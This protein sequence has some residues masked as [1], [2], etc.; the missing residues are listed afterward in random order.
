MAENVNPLPTVSE[1]DL[2]FCVTV[3]NNL[4]ARCGISHTISSISQCSPSLFV[5][6]FE[7]LFHFRL[8]NIHREKKQTSVEKL[9]NMKELISTMEWTVGFSLQHINAQGILNGEPKHLCLLIQIFKEL[10]NIVEHRKEKE[11][12]L[13]R[14]RTPVPSDLEQDEEEAPQTEADEVSE[15]CDTVLREQGLTEHVKDVVTLNPDY[16]MSSSSS[17]NLRTPVQLLSLSSQQ[18][19]GKDGQAW[20]QGYSTNSDD[21]PRE[22]TLHADPVAHLLH[23]RPL[24]AAAMHQLPQPL[25]ATDLRAPHLSPHAFLPMPKSHADEQFRVLLQEQQEAGEADRPMATAAPRDKPSPSLVTAD[26]QAQAGTSP[27][28]PH[29]PRASPALQPPAVYSPQSVHFTLQQLHGVSPLLS[30][31]LEG[32]FALDPLYLTPDPVYPAPLRPVAKAPATP[33]PAAATPT[34]PL[35][36]PQPTPSTATTTAMAGKAPK[37]ALKPGAQMQQRPSATK[38]QQ[39]QQPKQLPE[40]KHQAL[41]RRIIGDEKRE[42]L[43]ARRFL[44]QQQQ[45]LQSSVTTKKGSEQAALIKMFRLL[46][47]RERT[48]VSEERTRLKVQQREADKER[49]QKQAALEHYYMTQHEMLVEEMTKVAECRRAQER[50]QKQ[51][52]DK[53]RR[54]ARDRQMHSLQQ[55]YQKLRSQEDA[56]FHQSSIHGLVKCFGVEG[57]RSALA[58]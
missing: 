28:P 54:E 37:P 51:A 39:P 19:R 35:P 9:H 50:H 34:Q 27:K 17:P 31:E 56:R 45:M 48:R 58:G 49:A 10:C 2:S 46:L 6:L 57:M 13:Q 40:S 29:P 25:D 33:M 52:L 3:V 14:P 32:Q 8:P 15:W 47:K 43:R 7:G 4:L 41:K 5:L 53:L 44:E 24:V 1:G 26:A 21:H 11:L 55:Y 23:P 36:Q 42:M 30:S 18:Q 20:R 12:A 22:E 38:P 16:H